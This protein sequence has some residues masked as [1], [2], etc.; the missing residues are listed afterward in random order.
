MK[1]LLFVTLSLLVSMS[2][3]AQTCDEKDAVEILGVLPSCGAGCDSVSTVCSAAGI[4]QPGCSAC[5]AVLVGDG[6]AVEC[7]TGMYCRPEH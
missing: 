4:P 7:A 1:K 3:A 5:I 2:L 6:R